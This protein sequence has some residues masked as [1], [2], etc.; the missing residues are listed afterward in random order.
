MS[1]VHLDGDQKLDMVIGARQ[2][3][4]ARL[5]FYFSDHDSPYSWA[6]R[7]PDREIL[8]LPNNGIAITTPPF[9]INLDGDSIA[10]VVGKVFTGQNI[11][12]YLYLSRS[13]KPMT[14]RSYDYD[15]ADVV[16]H[17]V[18]GRLPAIGALNDSSQRY[19]MLPLTGIGPHR[20]PALL[21]LSGGST[22]PNRTYD[23]WFPDD[24]ESLFARAQA[25]QDVTGDGWNDY[26]GA[27]ERWGAFVDQGIAIVL[28]G[29]PYI[30]TD[31]PSVSVQQLPI[32]GK[33]NAISLWPNPV[34][35]RLTIAWRG[36]LHPMP[37]RFELHDIN[38]RLLA[39]GNANPAL[40]SVV[41]NRGNT[42]SG[43]Y[44]LSTLDASGALIASA[45]IILQ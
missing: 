10:D 35:D 28:A 2:A 29:G 11:G 4:G 8:L 19:D 14:S 42:P 22:G 39:R 12:I 36:D 21:A 30:P 37:H 24:D 44:I 41:W 18:Y 5:K 34:H 26:L 3:G 1:F 13:G 20:G 32:A 16:F 45:T 31:D 38:G 40:G 25:L 23:A 33:P 6:N 9:F 27:N 15:D 17:T 7:N 43:T